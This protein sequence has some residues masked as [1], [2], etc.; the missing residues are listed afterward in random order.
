MVDKNEYFHV[1]QELSETPEIKKVRLCSREKRLQAADV[2]AG[3]TFESDPVDHGVFQNG[4]SQCSSPVA[5]LRLLNKPLETS[6]YK[7]F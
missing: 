4:E 3:A 1:W 5:H 2:Q 7:N 6:L